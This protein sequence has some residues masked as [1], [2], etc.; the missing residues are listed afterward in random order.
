MA[1]APEGADERSPFEALMLADDRRDGD[2]VIRVEGV[3][4]A[5]NESQAE[6][7]V[8]RCFHG[9]ISGFAS[10][11]LTA[12][13]NVFSRPAFESRALKLA[14]RRFHRP[15]SGWPVCVP[16][17]T[18]PPSKTSFFQIGTVFLTSSIAKRQ[19]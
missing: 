9:I 4:D 2:Q 8:K 11:L 7:G 5:E 10:R 12:R 14:T 6:G 1:E 17:H 18:S 16:I 13:E 19:A 15:G 3:L